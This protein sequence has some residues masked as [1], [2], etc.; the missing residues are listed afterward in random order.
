MPISPSLPGLSFGLSPSSSASTATGLDNMG[1]HG[2]GMTGDINIGGG[3]KSAL[4]RDLAVMVGIGLAA[5]YLWG[6]LA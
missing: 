5:K 2:G 6:R 4:L 3:G 1:G